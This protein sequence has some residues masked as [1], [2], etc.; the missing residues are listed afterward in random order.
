M[1]RDEQGREVRRRRPPGYQ[2]PAVDDDAWP[3]MEHSPFTIEGRIEQM[4]VMARGLGRRRYAG[5]RT[6]GIIVAIAMLAPIVIGTI[7]IAWSTLFN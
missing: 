2:E 6:V 3:A 5:K 7:S 1:E 4:G